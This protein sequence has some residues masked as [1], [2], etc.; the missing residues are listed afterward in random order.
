VQIGSL[1]GADH[2][3]PGFLDQV[4]QLIDMRR[5]AGA[6]QRLRRPRVKQRHQAFDM[7]RFLGDRIEQRCLRRR[8]GDAQPPPDRLS[9]VGALHDAT[10]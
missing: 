9:A 2:A 8:Q 4:V 6:R 5:D 1:A 3:E 7:H 10:A